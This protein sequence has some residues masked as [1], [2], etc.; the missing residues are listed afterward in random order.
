MN[1][2]NLIP[3]GK[4]NALLRAKA[5]AVSLLTAV[6][7]TTISADSAMAASHA[8]MHLTPNQISQMMTDH[9][10]AEPTQAAPDAAVSAPSFPATLS[11]LP[12]LP[13]VAAD[14][15]QG[16]CGN[17]WAWAGTG[18][19]EIAHNLQNDVASRLSVQLLNSCN[20]YV[21]CC[22]GGWLTSVAQ[23]YSFDGFAVPWD[24]TNGAWSSG[25]G[26]CGAP[27]GS[28]ATAPQFPIAASSVASIPTWGVS[29]A[30][31]IA[32]IKT[33]LNQKKAIW[34]AFFMTSDAFNTFFNFWDDEPESAQWGNFY[35]SETPNVNNPEEGHAVLCVGY[36][37]TDAAGPTWIMVNSWGTTSGRPNGIFHVSQNMDYG[38]AFA[39]GGQANEQILWETLNVQF[40]PQPSL[41]IALAGT[42]TVVLTWPSAAAGYTLQ[43]NSTLN[44][45]T[46]STVP[47]AP[48]LI[49][50]QYQVTLPKSSA[51]SFFRLMAP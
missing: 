47:N 1:T 24:N 28:I 38:S 43:R 30:Q 17:C 41:N 45:A 42:D 11:L 19:M 29:Q 8:L 14:R 49:A 9:L 7:V 32:N 39:P 44:A 12:W 3:F 18:V 21:N 34:F 33:V 13:Y 23:F 22:D 46:W 6:C 51:N 26:T 27:C 36:D 40:A 4:R 35:S 2:S 48:S 50:N 15:N 5:L 31:A 37:D 10:K 25:D 20:P 16:D